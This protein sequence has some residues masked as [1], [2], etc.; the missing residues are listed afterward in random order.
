MPENFEELL[1]DYT[2]AVGERVTATG[3][4]TGVITSEREYKRCREALVAYVKALE[5]E[6][7]TYKDAL[8]TIQIDTATQ[9]SFDNI[10]RVVAEA[11]EKYEEREG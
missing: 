1:L 9:S 5:D 10:Y 2:D 4:G 6:R 3:W 7:D 11:L 8:L